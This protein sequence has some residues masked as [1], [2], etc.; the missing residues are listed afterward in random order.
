MTW[1]DVATRFEEILQ[2]VVE[3][4]EQDRIRESQPHQGLRGRESGRDD[5]RL[6]SAS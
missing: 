4:S 1:P 6:P 2:S 5:S 3:E